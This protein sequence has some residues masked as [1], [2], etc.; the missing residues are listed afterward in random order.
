MAFTNHIAN[1]LGATTDNAF[2]SIL[3]GSGTVAVPYQTTTTDNTGG[4]YTAQL[5]PSPEQIGMA[6]VYGLCNRSPEPD[7]PSKFEC[8]T[9]MELIDEC[10]KLE[11]VISDKAKES[12]GVAEK[13]KALGFN[14]AHLNLAVKLDKQIRLE[15]IAEYDYIK[16]TNKDIEK[17]LEKKVARYNEECKPKS[18]KKA[19]IEQAEAS[20][21]QW[22]NMY[23]PITITTANIQPGLFHYVNQPEVAPSKTYISITKDTCHRR[24]SQ[25]GTIGYFKWKE[26]PVSDYNG[27]P[28]V[29][30]LETFA[31]HK[32]R[33]LFHDFTVAEVEGIHDPLLLGRIDG[34]DE[35]FFIAQWGDD[36][37][38]DDLL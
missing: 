20:L 16:I 25:K 28:P 30:I 27:I 19:D 22:A 26:T 24:S 13:L 6:E 12:I 21:Y 23:A 29:G 8:G 2:G 18:K 7:A 14:K 10:R 35:R 33:N 34:S 38:L 1:W 36:I 3:A 9:L 31:E 11:V 32:K 4:Y 37:Q 5:P 15:K 17:Y